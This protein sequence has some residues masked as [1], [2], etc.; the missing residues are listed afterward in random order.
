MKG[1]FLLAA[2]LLLSSFI[3]LLLASS[4]CSSYSF[5]LL[6]LLARYGFASFPLCAS[7]A[8]GIATGSQ[9]DSAG[10]R[11]ER[12]AAS[13]SAQ[14]TKHQKRPLLLWR[15]YAE[16]DHRGCENARG[17]SSYDGGNETKSNKQEKEI[18]YRET[19]VFSFFLGSCLRG[20]WKFGWRCGTSS[21]VFCEIGFVV[22][23]SRG[24]ERGL[25]SG[26]KAKRIRVYREAA[27]AFAVPNRDTDALFVNG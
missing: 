25:C 12:S 16:C 8:R 2:L 24:G 1:F 9:S 10:I 26:G 18:Q 27:H 5:L 22:R 23:S 3:I 21:Q 19:N 7:P 20:V 13:S 11:S 14:L 4:S 15:F 6:L 17:S